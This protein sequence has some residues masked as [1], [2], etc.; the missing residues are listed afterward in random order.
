MPFKVSPTVP[1][2]QGTDLGLLLYKALQ[3][4]HRAL[5]NK[6]AQGTTAKARGTTAKAR[7][8]TVIAVDAVLQS[9]LLY[10]LYAILKNF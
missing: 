6:K 2:K 9:L 3:Q 5:S 10:L 8:T 1:I 4:K 7:G